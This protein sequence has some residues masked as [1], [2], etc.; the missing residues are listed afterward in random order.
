M[1]ARNRIRLVILLFL[2]ILSVFGTTKLSCSV[3]A[4]SPLLFLTGF[5]R[6]GTVPFGIGMIICAVSLLKRRFFC[7]YCCPMGTVLDW[8]YW[9]RRRLVRKKFHFF[10]V[11]YFGF[12]FLNLLFLV[13]A[14]LSAAG[15]SLFPFSGF[16]FDPIILFTR[17][18][19]SFPFIGCAGWVFFLSFILSPFFWRFNV[20]PCGLLQ[21]IMF[22]VFHPHSFVRLYSR[23]QTQNFPVADVKRRQFF[24][25]GGV[26][27]GGIYLAL[28]GLTR[29]VAVSKPRFRPPGALKA[30]Q[31]SALCSRCGKCAEV[32][33]THLIR[34]VQFSTAEIFEAGTPE[35]LF[36]NGKYCESECSSCTSVC[37]TGAIRSLSL[38]E[39]KKERIGIV[40]FEFK[41]C[42]LYYQQE[43]SICRRECPLG[44]IR[45]VWSEDEYSEIPKIDLNVC[46]GC[47]KCLTFCPGWNEN[48]PFNIIPIEGEES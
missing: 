47:G 28:Y 2:G 31:F 17:N 13:T 24:K 46:N 12:P 9:I 22:G 8:L 5:V 4:V 37:P 34:P 44:A 15:F 38:A 19:L 20:C 36:E 27:A 16:I 14:F 11:R 29:R 1:T 26:I 18:L 7:R 33:P 42:R 21:D 25:R 48:K 3:F 10:R 39:K 23:T 35:I 40:A 43:C 45:F 30:G 41:N 6:W 32:C